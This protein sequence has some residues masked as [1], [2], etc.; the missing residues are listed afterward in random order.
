[1]RASAANADSDWLEH[2]WPNA[3]GNININNNASGA[4]TGSTNA[5]GAG[6]VGESA[7]GRSARSAGFHP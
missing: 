2:A 5:F 3:V 1:V 7:L 4:Y 6:N